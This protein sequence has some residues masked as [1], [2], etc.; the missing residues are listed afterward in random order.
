MVDKGD[1]ED[2]E[3]TFS[4]FQFLDYYHWSF[5]INSH[6]N[7]IALTKVTHQ[8]NFLIFNVKLSFS[9]DI[10]MARITTVINP[11]TK[12]WIGRFSTNKQFHNFGNRTF[13]S[14]PEG[15]DAD[16]CLKIIV[17]ICL[18]V[19]DLFF[20]KYWNYNDII[21]IWFA[22]QIYLNP[23]FLRD[24][25]SPSYESVPNSSQSQ[26]VAGRERR[27][28]QI[29]SLLL[30]GR[31]LSLIFSFR[32]LCPNISFVCQMRLFWEKQ[33]CTISVMVIV[34]IYQIKGSLCMNE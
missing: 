18:G 21:I 27:S 15:E 23:A 28:S 19:S 1:K 26:L 32:H 3:Q 34:K 17:R 22:P 16:I 5:D 11:S 10:S 13:L 30:L 8:V 33:A 31:F 7:I 6:L 9:V 4:H 14:S 2:T 25:V 20:D 29:D 12:L 24:T